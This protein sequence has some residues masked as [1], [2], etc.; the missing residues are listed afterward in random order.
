MAGGLNTDLGVGTKLPKPSKINLRSV[1][2]HVHRK[3]PCIIDVLMT[4][5]LV[6][7]PVLPYCDTHDMVSNIRDWHLICK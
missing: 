5:Y 2:L 1:A 4:P 6:F 7:L 3:Y